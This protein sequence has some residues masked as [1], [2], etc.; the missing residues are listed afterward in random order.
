MLV[1]NE[2]RARILT[3]PNFTSESSP[4]R[5]QHVRRQRSGARR[6]L[7]TDANADRESRIVV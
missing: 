2:L 3:A 7:R 1:L 5:N 6:R 4:A